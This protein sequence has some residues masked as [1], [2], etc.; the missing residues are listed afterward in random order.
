MRIVGPTRW[1]VPL[2]GRPR[3]THAGAGS[4][5]PGTRSF[6]L[7]DRWTIHIYH[8]AAGFEVDGVPYDL[9]PGHIAVMPPGTRKTYVFREPESEHCC[10]HFRLAASCP[11]PRA[12]GAMIDLEEDFRR[13]DG[14]M[15]QM[16]QLFPADPH[17]AAVKLWDVLLGLQD[18]SWQGEGAGADRAVRIA[19]RL[20]EL[21]LHRRIDIP[22][23]ARRSGMSHNH[24]IRL[25]RRVHGMTIRD[26]IMARR[27]QR[28]E[29]LITGSTRAIKEVASEVG[30]PDLH[31]FNK[32]VRAFFGCAP[33]SLRAWRRS[34]RAP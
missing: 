18:A 29:H 19:A 6:S 34:R 1:N 32:A 8:Y 28:A 7:P 26:Y 30:I 14:A 3:I 16:V 25:F 13:V 22:D 10:A 33:R 15:A 2:D 12:I 17:R 20:I 5:R 31:R 21:H 9:R 23:L 4:F 11:S 24:L 27:M